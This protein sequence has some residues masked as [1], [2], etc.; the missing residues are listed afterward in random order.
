[1]SYDN[2]P[3]PPP[4]YPEEAPAAG[5]PVHVS[6]QKPAPTIRTSPEFD[7]VAGALARAQGAFPEL[8]RAAQATVE[9]KDR[10]TG[11]KRAETYTYATLADVLACIRKPLSEN[12]IALVQAPVQVGPGKHVMLTRL[13]HASGQW[14]E[15]ETPMFLGEFVNAQRYGGA[16][17][18]ARRYG[19]QMITGLAAEEDDDGHKSQG[20]EAQTGLRPARDEQEAPPA[21][22]PAPRRTSS[23][24]RPAPKPRAEP[25]DGVEA[26][27][28]ELMDEFTKADNQVEAARLWIRRYPDLVAIARQNTG[29]AEMVA[30]AAAHT[31]PNVKFNRANDRTGEVASAEIDGKLVEPDEPATQKDAA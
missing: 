2:D 9:F 31:W 22:D 23:R 6:V 13:I 29:Y 19:V 3:G 14:I 11:T 10:A 24:E 12:E 30:E 27:S 5:A 15:S 25:D 16:A 26:R 1:M 7:Q 20:N 28:R 21:N 8:K 4:A 18:Y 17:T